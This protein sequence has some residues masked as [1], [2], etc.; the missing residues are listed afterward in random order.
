MAESHGEHPYEILSA[1]EVQERTGSSIH[2]GAAFE[3]SAAIVQPALLARGLRRVAVE[4]GVRIFEWTPMVE[5]DRE[6]GRVRTASGSVRADAV[7]LAVNAWATKIRELR[8]AVVAVS[9]D[10]VATAP[11]GE[12]LEESGWTGGEA[13]SDCRL[14]VHYYRPTRDGRVA[15]GRGGG[16]LAFGGR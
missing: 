16:R 13:V 4:R 14:L 15:F 6:D 12:K 9:S 8:R 1:K 10:M 5:L 2:L 7:V 11:M 3:K